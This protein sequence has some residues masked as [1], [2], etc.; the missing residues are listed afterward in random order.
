MQINE[1]G[2]VQAIKGRMEI[3][4]GIKMMN[5][6]ILTEKSMNVILLGKKGIVTRKYTRHHMESNA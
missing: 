3:W 2:F 6:E 5:G 4:V 1:E